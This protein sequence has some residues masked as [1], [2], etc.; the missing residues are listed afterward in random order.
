VSNNAALAATPASV[1]VVGLLLGP[2]INN[3]V[4][5]PI[6]LFG[7]IAFAFWSSCRLRR[8]CNLYMA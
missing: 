2:L 5:G 7:T 8:S 4:V 3:S 6:V 1:S